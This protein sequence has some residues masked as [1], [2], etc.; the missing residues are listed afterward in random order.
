[1]VGAPAPLQLLIQPLNGPRPLLLD[2]W[3]GL[4]QLLGQGALG[5]EGHQKLDALVS[6]FL[7]VALRS[8]DCVEK[9]WKIL[10]NIQSS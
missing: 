1:M 5:E 9:T 10:K 4:K 3:R 2:V 7:V 8:G 6:S